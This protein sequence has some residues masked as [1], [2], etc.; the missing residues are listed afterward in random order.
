MGSGWLLDACP[1]LVPPSRAERLEDVAATLE[2]LWVSYNG[3]SSLDGIAAC[4]RLEVLYM[5]NNM[6]RR[7]DERRTPSPPQWPRSRGW[8]VEASCGGLT[9][10]SLRRRVTRHPPPLSAHPPPRAADQGLGG[11]GQARVA[12]AAARRA[13]CGE[14]H[15]RGIGQGS[16]PAAGEPASQ[17]AHGGPTA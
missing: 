15:L 11:T 10:L 2:E 3:I 8:V 13:V 12:A 16:G 5:S 1:F 7:P 4:Q 14:P 9:A 17:P 6:V